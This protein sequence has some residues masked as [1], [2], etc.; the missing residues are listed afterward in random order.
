MDSQIRGGK[1]IIACGRWS[2]MGGAVAIQRSKIENCNHSQRIPR[3]SLNTRAAIGPERSAAH[4]LVGFK[5]LLT[6]ILSFPRLKMS[7]VSFPSG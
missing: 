4:K 2:R 3:Q 1:E 6:I 5:I 7:F